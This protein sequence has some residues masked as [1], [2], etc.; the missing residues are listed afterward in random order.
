MAAE[1]NFENRIKIF[2]QSVG[3]YALGTPV[4]NMKVPPIGYYEKRWGNKMTK[5]GL[6]DLHI[7]IR[8]ISLEIEIKAPKGKASELQKHFVEQIVE[9]K[10]N[11]AILYEHHKDIP[12]DGFQYYIDYKQ[13]RE[14]VCYHAKVG[15][16]YAI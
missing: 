7:V 12:D 11:A 8:G 13:F 6:P 9:S 16:E 1:K 5:S 3:V 15:A 10:C 4:Q 2:L 14:V